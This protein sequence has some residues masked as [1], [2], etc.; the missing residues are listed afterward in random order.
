MRCC[1]LTVALLMVGATAVRAQGGMHSHAPAAAGDS[2]PP[3]NLPLRFRVSAPIS[4][5]HSG[6]TGWIIDSEQ[7]YC[8]VMRSADADSGVYLIS[9]IDS[10][11]VADTS[12]ARLGS[13]TFL[14]ANLAP[15]KAKYG[16]CGLPHGH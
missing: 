16:K 3:E 13:L 7:G 12:A 14:P 6:K 8:P 11:Q 5:W 10:L 4:A 9:G 15:I 1:C 2:V